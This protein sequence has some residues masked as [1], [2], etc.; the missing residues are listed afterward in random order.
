L[1]T[2]HVGEEQREVVLGARVESSLEVTL[3]SSFTLQLLDDAVLCIL[4]HVT[5]GAQS[6]PI[7]ATFG[8]HAAKI[9]LNDKHLWANST[10]NSTPPST[11]LQLTPNRLHV[12]GRNSTLRSFKPHV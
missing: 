7:G 2:F 3:H 11:R 9:L 5:F 8:E 4:L 10:I 1:L 6:Q 12:A